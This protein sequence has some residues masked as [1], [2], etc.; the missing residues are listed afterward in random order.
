M[1]AMELH[2]FI[3]PQQGASYSAVQRLAQAVEQLGFAGFFT[4]DH[5]LRMGDGDPAPGPLD[6]WTTLAGLAR[7]TDRV[8][9]GTL[10]SPITFRTPGQ[11]AII[12]AQIDEMSGGRVELGLGAGWFE[13]EH[14]AHAIPFPALGERFGRL[15]E[16]LEILRGHWA[17]RPQQPFSYDGR[18]YRVTGSPGLP[19]PVQQPHPPIIIGG[20]GTTVTPRLAAR[21]AAEFNVPF[22]QPD[23][24]GAACDRVRRAMTRAPAR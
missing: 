13:Q 12:V 3:E 9:L 4:S 19:R 6:A 8:R 24:W 11:L 14:Q 1:L 17:A 18:H 21:F 5:Y 7:D 16:Q 23:D 22:P 15:T 20:W 2:V 10:V